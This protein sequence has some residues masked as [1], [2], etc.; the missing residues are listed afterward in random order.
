MNI[1]GIKIRTAEGRHNF[2]SDNED[3]AIVKDDAD[4][5]SIINSSG[6]SSQEIKTCLQLSRAAVKS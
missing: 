6:D 1:K 3:T 4:L 5:G 2:N